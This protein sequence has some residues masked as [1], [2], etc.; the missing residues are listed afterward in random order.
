MASSWILQEIE[1]VK[2]LQNIMYSKEIG[3]DVQL[4]VAKAA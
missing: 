3:S 4:G 1:K 2:C